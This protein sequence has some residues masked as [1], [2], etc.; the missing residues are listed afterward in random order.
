MKQRPKGGQRRVDGERRVAGRL[1]RMGN[2]KQRNSSKAHRAM[3]RMGGSESVVRPAVWQPK[4]HAW[5]WWGRRDQLGI[6]EQKLLRPATSTTEQSSKPQT[7]RQNRCKHKSR[8]HRC[9]T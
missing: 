8:K 1:E 7:T 2:M 5:L 4:V 6:L 9:T 3:D